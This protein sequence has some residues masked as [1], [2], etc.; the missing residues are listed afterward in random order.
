MGAIAHDIY[1]IDRDTF[2]FAFVIPAANFFAVALVTN[3]SFVSQQNLNS[4]NAFL[5]PAYQTNVIMFL[6]E[7][8]SHQIYTKINHNQ[9]TAQAASIASAVND[10]IVLRFTFS[11][12]ELIIT[13]TTQNTVLF[14]QILN[15]DYF[16]APYSLL[17]QA[18]GGTF[19]F[20]FDTNF[21]VQQ[22]ALSLPLPPNPNNKTYR[23]V[24][25]GASSIFDFKLLKN[26]DF[27]TFYNEA[28]N[29]MVSRLYT[30]EQ[31]NTL[32]NTAITDALESGGA[33]YNAIQAAVNP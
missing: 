33:I 11:T 14:S 15:E 21:A 1:A 7:G 25:A 30:D 19:S 9:P 31:I 8:Q 13:N 18:Q 5:N 32:A 26:G 16:N 17:V 24:N 2:E 29:I 22:Y 12:R 20:N 27:A 4:V 3:A 6:G 28:A 10:D 23:V